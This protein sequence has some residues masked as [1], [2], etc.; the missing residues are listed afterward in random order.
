MPITPQTPM[1]VMGAVPHRS[2]MMPLSQSQ[3]DAL[4][5][6]SSSHS[7]DEGNQPPG[8]STDTRSSALNAA[9]LSAMGVTKKTEFSAKVAGWLGGNVQPKPKP[10]VNGAIES[11]SSNFSTSRRTSSHSMSPNPL[12]APVSGPAAGAALDSLPVSRSPIADDELVAALTGARK[13]GKHHDDDDVQSNSSKGS[14]WM[15][16]L[17]E[18]NK[19]YE[20]SSARKKKA[21]Q[22]H[23]HHHQSHH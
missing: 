7:D 8:E 4:S 6:L 14:E 20:E 23:H 2:M 13:G 22:H 19:E 1:A 12:K 9:A 11:C 18:L 3:E 15:Y 5:S 10:T 17:D 16:N 21:Q